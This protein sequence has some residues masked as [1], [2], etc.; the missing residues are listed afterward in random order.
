MRKGET[1]PIQKTIWQASCLLVQQISKSS[2]IVVAI[3]IS[4]WQVASLHS[5]K[6]ALIEISDG[7][8]AGPKWIPQKKVEN[9]QISLFKTV[10]TQQLMK[11]VYNFK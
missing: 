5:V 9:I 1:S 2:S 7:R 8:S 11:Y 6:H 4:R 3:Q 10:T